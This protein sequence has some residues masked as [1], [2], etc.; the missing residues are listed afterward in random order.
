MR[1]ECG[2]TVPGEIE[3]LGELYGDWVYADFARDHRF[4][5]IL[6]GVR[7]P[8]KN[9]IFPGFFTGVRPMVGVFCFWRSR[10]GDLHC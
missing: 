10:P 3:F 2:G 9:F 5:C 4:K 8:R 7:R 1:F 6:L